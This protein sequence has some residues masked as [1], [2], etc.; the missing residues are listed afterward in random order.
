MFNVTTLEP[1]IDVNAQQIAKMASITVQHIDSLRQSLIFQIDD[2]TVS[3]IGDTLIMVN[4]FMGLC[5]FLQNVH[6]DE[7]LKSFINEQMINVNSGIVDITDDR[8]FYDILLEVKEKM[9]LDGEDLRLVECLLQDMK[10]DGVHL[11]PEQQQLLQ[12]VCVKLNRNESRFNRNITRDDSFMLATEEDLTGVPPHILSML[13]K[14]EGKYKVTMDYHIYYEILKYAS[15]RDFREKIETFF[16]S[17]FVPTNLG[18]LAKM[19]KLRRMKAQI[20]GYKNYVDYVTDGLMGKNYETVMKML[21]DLYKLIKN[22]CR[23]EDDLMCQFGGTDQIG[24]W[25]LSF[26]QR[27]IKEQL[28][29]VNEEELLD[30]FPTDFALNQMFEIFRELFKLKFVNVTDANRGAKY[31]DDVMIYQVEDELF[32]GKVI[33]F[34]IL[35]LFPRSDPNHSPKYKHAACFAIRSASTLNGVQQIPITGLVTSFTPAN[36]AL[37]KPSLLNLKE[38]TTLFHELGHGIHNILGRA[39]HEMFAGTN[40]RQKDMVELQSQILEEFLR[41]PQFIVRLSK[42]Y[43]TGQPLKMD[44]AIKVA[45]SVKLFQANQLLRQVVFALYDLLIH[46]DNNIIEM[47]YKKLQANDSLFMSKLFQMAHRVLH[48]KIKI[49]PKNSLPANFGHL[50]GGYDARYYTYVLSK[51]GAIDGFRTGFKT[52]IN[53]EN[54]LRY[55]QTMLQSGGKVDVEKMFMD[56]LG[57]PMDLNQVAEYL[58]ESL[59]AYI[60]TE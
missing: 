27:I 3:R 57:R 52:G 47:A 17:R 58:Q 15:N 7:S 36:T 33:G 56:F 45:N 16:N 54:G 13:K 60:A 24:T 38:L 8:R 53:L 22:Y 48:E 23:F 37:G 26:L 31:V 43:K 59:P 49:S 42:H 28:L 39:R 25:D 50:G 21:Q 18:H 10:R 11:P 51:G 29:H 6:P 20:L 35:D 44:V 12:E 46:G 1:L 30:Y 5:N 14:E 2:Q 34:M 55:R 4:N 41:I 32:Q 9:P 40:L 19:V